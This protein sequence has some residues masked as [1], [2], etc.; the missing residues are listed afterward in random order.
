LDSNCG[1]NMKLTVDLIDE[2]SESLVGYIRK[3]PLEYSPVLSEKYKTPVYLKL[4]FL[5][6]TGSFKL[7]GAF[8]KL[9]RLS[10]ELKKQ[11]VATCSAGN[12]GW[13]MAYAGKQLNIPITVYLP[14]SVDPSKK[15]GIESLGATTI[16]TESQGYDG[17]EK[18]AIQDSLRLGFPFVSAFDEPE[19]MAAN[20]GSLAQEIIDENPGLETFI[21]PV[22]GG[23]LGAGLGVLIKNIKPDATL[24]GCQHIE[25]PGLKLSIE[26][27]EAITSLP[28]I[29]TVAGGIEG[30]IGANTFPYIQKTIDEVVLLSEKEIR[31][32]VVWMLDHHHYLIE[33]SS[34]AALATLSFS[35]LEELAGPTVVVLTGR[36]I[37][38]D[39]LKSIIRKDGY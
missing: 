30:G 5:Q 6:T 7:R 16:V 10:T 27:G 26:K 34:A 15:A 28:P 29:E 25:S 14:K 11:G 24:I 33:P 23:G 19:I 21:Y 1:E 20:G 38:L 39:T 32:G 31:R 18:Y 2:A 36:N 3:T 9:L 8:F 37:A 22:S 13:A 12:H 35:K 17:A 4:E